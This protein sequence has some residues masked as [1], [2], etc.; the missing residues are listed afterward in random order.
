ME[1]PIITFEDIKPDV[2]IYFV[3]GMSGTGKTTVSRKIAEKLTNEK[4]TNEEFAYKKISVDEVLREYAKTHPDGMRLTRMYKPDRY[5]KEKEVVIKSIRALIDKYKKAIIEGAIWDPYFITKIAEGYT[6][7]L[8]YVKPSSNERYEQNILRRV[9]TDL[10]EGTK[11]IS[12]VWKSLPEE[13]IRNPETLKRFVK[14]MVAWRL[15][16]VVDDYEI[17]KNFDMVVLEN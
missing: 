9:E 13:K 14:K 7:K 2:D 12:I 4:L 5:P 17:F 8:V 16:H 15:R 10:K 6:Y 11:K 1:P 3:I